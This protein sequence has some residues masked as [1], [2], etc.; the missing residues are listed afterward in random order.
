M[1]PLERAKAHKRLGKNSGTPCSGLTSLQGVC[2]AM[3]A[4]V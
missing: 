4:R 3:T 1:R 2:G